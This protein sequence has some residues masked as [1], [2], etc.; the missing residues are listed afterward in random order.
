MGTQPGFFDIEDR[1]KRLSDLGDQLEAYAAAVDFAIFRSDLEKALNYS[2]GAKGGRPPFDP[3]LMMKV[4]V[5][6]AQNNLSDDRAEFL[7]SDRLSFMRFLGLGL[8]DKAPDAKTIWAFRERLTRAGAI[9]GLFKRFEKALQDAGY[10]AMS[11]Q[12]VDSTLIAA[13]KQRNSDDEKRQVKDGKSAA[14]IWPENPAKARQKDTSARW[15]V[16]FGKARL[17][18]DG[19]PMPDIAIPSFGYKAHT[20][21]DRKHRLIRRW[22]VTDAA[23]HD[24]RMLRRGLLDPSNTAS[25]V[26]ADSAYRSR[27][28]EAF[29][30]RHGFTSHVHHRRKPGKPM[31]LHVRRGNATRSKHPAPIE[32]VFA[33]Q[34]QAMSLTIRTIGIAR[35]KVKIGIANFAYNIRRLVQIQKTEAA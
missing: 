5:I 12:L 28:N 2:D 23:A 32:H 31:P 1:L 20:S 27:K 9:D 8:H 25:G 29:M 26:W 17:R 21:I 34:K 10:I 16:Q 15:T 35:A 33:V 11:G 30:E 7:I 4:L 22:D 6:Q 13:P 19:R 3:V 18:E 14:Q 24:G